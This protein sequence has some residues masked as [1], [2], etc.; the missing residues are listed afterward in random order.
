ME[1]KS[2]NIIYGA[3][4]AI[5]VIAMGYILSRPSRI[6]V[7]TSKAER[8][9]MRVT[10]DGEGM[11]RVQDR[12]VIASPVNGRLKRLIL[13][14]GDEVKAGDVVAQIEA[15]PLSPLDPRQSSEA[16]SRVR[17]AESAKLEAEANL[18]KIQNELEQA[19]RE[20]E[21]S[22]NVMD[23]GR[24]SQ[25]DYERKLNAEKTL[26][27]D[28][29]AANIR[30]RGAEQKI[31]QAVAVKK[32][33]EANIERINNNLQQAKRESKR[34]ADLL[35]SGD[36]SRE[37]F[38]RTRLAEQTL[39][40]ELDAAK[41]RL[42]AAHSDIQLAK[43]NKS[44]AKTNIEHI[45]EDLAQARR[46]T[47]RAKNVLTYGK[48]SGQDYEQRL[49]YE[50]TLEKELEAARFRVRAAVNEVERAK[51]S[52]LGGD[53]VGDS[54]AV[55]APIDG[56]VLKVLEESE[57]VVNAGTPLVELSNPTN[58][59]VV[60]DILSTDAVKIKSGEA[61][62]IGGWGE[63]KTV[64]AK[65]RLI[66]P[67]AFTKV[68]SLGIEEQR[69]N[70]I[71]DFLKQPPNLGDGYRVE[72]KIVVWEANSILKIP[73]SALFRKGE[74]WSVFVVENGKALQRDVKIGQRNADEAEILEGIEAET[75]VI[76]HPTNDLTDGGY[77]EIKTS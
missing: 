21:R 2:R 43:E 1:R 64:E 10:V 16:N 75:E 20:R 62:T 69:V 67:S 71:A 38:E 66:E 65:V 50:K 22:K 18:Q 61:M 24:V 23:Y 63:N 6:L 17:V 30:E 46:E 59:E 52:L 32:E 48:T 39:I 72:A 77:V 15:M 68:S 42:Q 47:V 31:L 37:E 19:R 58:L 34:A 9:Q 11:T 25:E 54:T 53:S 3:I 35:E 14:R 73:A 49:S 40:K 29:E 13:R 27:K 56:R 7:E 74:G 57:R 70:I 60:V 4:A 55:Y 5:I 33:V 44:E 41:Y 36:I 26:V 45:Q 76:L 51:S 12:F 8:G 28:L